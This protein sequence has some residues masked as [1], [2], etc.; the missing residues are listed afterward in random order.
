[1][2]TQLIEKPKGSFASSYDALEQAAKTE[3]D[4]L[5]ATFGQ[6]DE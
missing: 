5:I 3:L 4:N 2:L 6:R 1:M